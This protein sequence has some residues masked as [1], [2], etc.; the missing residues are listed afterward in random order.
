MRLP[1]YYSASGMPTTLLLRADGTLA[2]LHMGEISKEPLD[3]KID[4]IAASR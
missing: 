3:A 2:S 4:R 1:R